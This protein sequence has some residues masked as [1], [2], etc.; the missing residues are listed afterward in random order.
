M[1]V[2]TKNVKSKYL[3]LSLFLI[4]L[5]L[6]SFF[7]PATRPAW[8]MLDTALFKFLNQTLENSPAAQLFWGIVNH[9]KADLV[10]D[11]IFLAFFT[12]A[13]VKAPAGQKVH[14]A[15]QFILCIIISASIIYFVNQIVLRNHLLIPRPSPSL[16]VT[17]CVR[18]SQEMPWLLSKDA[19]LGSFPGDHATTLLLFASFY[20]LYAGRRAGAIA[21]LYAIF[22]MLPRLIIGAHWLSDI[23]VG[24]ASLVLFFLSLLFCTPLQA[25][26]VGKIEDFLNLWRQD[27]TYKKTV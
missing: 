21:W 27:E 9:K 3:F 22:R 19:T 10:E 23:V 8:E 18:L 25:W 11:A 20:T 2:S 16:V 5:L 13:I 15:S 7:S 14:R 26:A 12:I 24:S 4:I 1:E 17:P 6:G